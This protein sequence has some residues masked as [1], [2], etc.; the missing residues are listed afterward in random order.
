MWRFLFVDISVQV[1]QAL[2]LM[3]TQPKKVKMCF[4]TQKNCSQTYMEFVFTIAQ[5]QKQASGLYSTK[6]KESVLHPDTEM[7]L[8]T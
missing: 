5:R 4:C 7:W 2:T 3:F 8:G 6:V 1:T